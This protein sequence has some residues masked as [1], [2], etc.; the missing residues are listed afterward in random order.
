MSGSVEFDPDQQQLVI[1]FPYRED[2]VAVVKELPG[3]R[4]DPKQKC[5]R[6][7]SSQVTAVYQALS[8][9]LFDFAPEVPALLAGTL[10]QA[11]P[12][13]QP[14]K[15]EAAPRD[16]APRQA[17]L[18]LAGAAAP[19][20]HSAE[21]PADAPPTLRISQLNTLVRDGLRRQFPDSFWLCGEVADFDKSA[22]RQHRFFQLVEK[23]PQQPR[24]LAVVEVA[25]FGSTAERLAQKLAA[26]DGAALRDGV[27]VRVLVKIDFYVGTGRF[28]VV[29]QD[30]DPSFTLGKLALARQQLLRDLRDQGL[31]HRNRSLGLPVPALRLGVLSSPDADGWHD[32]LQH[33]HEAPLG[34]DVTLLPIK[35]QGAELRPTLLAG[36][37][38]FA[39]HAEQFD[40]LCIVRGGGSRTDLGGFDDRDVAFAVARHPLK[41]LVGIGHQRDESVLDLI[42]HSAK[43]PTALAELLVAAALDARHHVHEQG[44]RL[45][46]AVQNHLDREQRHLTHQGRRL[47][48][49]A[50]RRVHQA[51]LALVATARGTTTA[52]QWLLQRERTGL[53]TTA[54]R[55]A[56]ATAYKLERAH[57]AL[58]EQQARLRLLDPA[59]VLR[60]GF[61]MVHTQ[62]GRVAPDA[63]RLAPAAQIE[64][65]FRD[66][67]IAAQVLS[68]RPNTP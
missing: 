15:L 65:R 63:A 28:Q 67:R 58:A 35:V 12:T 45:A 8:R 21:V 2:L 14:P 62:D 20:A 39:A 26:D 56:T 57:S 5:W 41:I 46:E 44:L 47:A 22:G 40:A 17:S 25:L 30:L 23:A 9:H 64:L 16:R 55:L 37:R 33:L 48:L 7:P 50:Q 59:A 29:V 32:F 1:R 24:P 31:Y 6:V 13:P 49:S 36:L 18:P 51:R 54:R 11:A 3:R 38:W 10:G 66:G 27:E 53:A 34:F 60:R 42:A 43:T 4:W 19:A 61:A 52:V 68:V